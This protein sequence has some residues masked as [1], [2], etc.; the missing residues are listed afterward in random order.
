MGEHKENAI[1]NAARLENTSEAKQ[2]KRKTK[3]TKKCKLL[4]KR[5]QRG[6][7][8][9]WIYK[10][11]LPR[12]I[13]LFGRNSFWPKKKAENQ[14]RLRQRTCGHFCIFTISSRR[15]VMNTEL[16]VS[17]SHPLCRTKPAQFSCS[18]RQGQQQSKLK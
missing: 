17:F 16:P 14:N 3:E 15:I 10:E 8:R 9:A 7:L 1:N 5:A 4:R 11:R 18:M 13:S 6:S 2:E 12:L